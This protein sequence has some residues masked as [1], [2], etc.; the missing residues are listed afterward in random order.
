VRR[1]RLAVSLASLALVGVLGGAG[2][3]VW[4]AKVADAQRLVAQQ[5]FTQVRQLANQLVFKYQDQLE[6]LSGATAVRQT[7]LTDAVEFLGNLREA[8][9]DDPA[10][11]RELAQSYYRI[12]LLQ[13]VNATIN[14]EQIQRA[15]ATLDQALALAQLYVD[16]PETTPAMVA[17]VVDMWAS[18]GEMRQRQGSLNEA[19]QAMDKALALLAPALVAAPNHQGVLTSAVGAQ[20]LMG[21]VLGTSVSYAN[22]G[23]L[24]QA[25]LH[26]ETAMDVAQRMVKLDPEDVESQNALAFSMGELANLEAQQGHEAQALALFQ[27]QAAMRDANAQALPDDVQFARRV[28]RQLGGGAGHEWAASFGAADAGRSAAADAATRG[29]RPRQPRQRTPHQQ[30]DDFQC[31]AAHLGG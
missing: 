27:R 23:L 12:S 21:R 22:L 15:E 25:R 10:L 30:F 1:N 7:L 11:A 3:A 17:D 29:K 31:P 19:R 14:T 24:N 28:A 16:R 6:Y 2:V 18:K 5:R 4:Q 8:A 13:G 20:G 26:L 9:E